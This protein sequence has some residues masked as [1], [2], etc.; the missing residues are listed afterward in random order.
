MF[1][2]ER[3]LGASLAD[4]GKVHLQVHVARVAPTARA[5]LRIADDGAEPALSERR[6][7]APDCEKLVDTLAV[8]IALAIEAA[9]PP[10]E[11]TPPAVSAATGP[12]SPEPAQFATTPTPSPPGVSP[13]DQPTPEALPPDAAPPGPIPHVFARLLGDVGSLPAPAVGVGVGAGLSGSLWRAELSGALW[14]DRHASLDS[15]STPGAGADVSLVTGTVGACALP[16]GE[17]SVQLALCASWEMGRLSGV[18]TGI[19]S[20]RRASGLWLAPGIEAGF[21]WRPAATRLG[22]GARL[23][24]FAPL[25]QREFFLERL[26]T[27]HEVESLVARA[28]VSVDVALR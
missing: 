19:T 2:V 8:A 6:L 20:P 3:A 9:A 11:A 5:L 22:I 15:V 18:G 24:A 10:P 1:Q 16:L 12:S 27:V 17:N 28:G 25:G 14:G 21:T 7:V 4:T 13:L 26:G 23:G